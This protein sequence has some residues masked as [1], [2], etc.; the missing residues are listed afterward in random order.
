MPLSLKNQRMPCSDSQDEAATSC[1]PP[2]KAHTPDPDEEKRNNPSNSKDSQEHTPSVKPFKLPPVSSFDKEQSEQVSSRKSQQ[3]YKPH[4]WL[5]G[6]RTVDVTSNSMSRGS[7]SE[8]E[9]DHA[10]AE[11][12][13]TAVS[14]TGKETTA[15]SERSRV[16]RRVMDATREETED[17]AAEN[18]NSERYSKRDL[19]SRGS[20]SP[21]PYQSDIYRSH[22]E[23]PSFRE[24]RLRPVDGHPRNKDHPIRSL[25]PPP[26][27]PYRPGRHS[28]PG[29]SDQ[30]V[31][32]DS[33]GDVMQFRSLVPVQPYNSSYDQAV[34]EHQSQALTHQ[35]P[36]RLSE[37]R[38]ADIAPPPGSA[39]AAYSS[40]LTPFIYKLFCLVSD[41]ATN[42]LC[43]WSMNGDSF[44]VPDPTAFAA[45][46]LP[47]YFKHNQFASFVRQLN[48]YRFHKLTPGTCIFGHEKFLKDRPDLLPEIVRQRSPDRPSSLGVQT[49]SPPFASLPYNSSA[50]H[51]SYGAPHPPDFKSTASH[52]QNLSDTWH[53]RQQGHECDSGL[54]VAY[55]HD[56]RHGAASAMQKANVR[57]APSRHHLYSQN[58]SSG[59]N[60]DGY[61]V[62]MYRTGGLYGRRSDF[63]QLEQ[64]AP[65]TRGGDDHADY[66]PI[67]SKRQRLALD[68]EQPEQNRRVFPALAVEERASSDVSRGLY[69][70][71]RRSSGGG[72]R[73]GEHEFYWMD[74]ILRRL[75]ALERGQHDIFGRVS[76]LEDH[77]GRIAAAVESIEKT[78]V[79]DRR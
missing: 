29:L 9:V 8:I 34:N 22:R 18:Q 36:L 72:A 19:S 21:R 66:G 71:Q 3:H 45:R 47:Q 14:L 56:Y 39:I 32:P 68:I 49:S 55:G 79:K 76:S 13:K 63:L 37:K 78:L 27:N 46:V 65:R 15:D 5:N 20:L 2:A 31:Q 58:E 17:D 30:K 75:Q 43:H 77:L 11:V 4:H 25:S 23:Q 62:S 67:A 59:E 6:S 64:A 50:P 7:N 24:S 53:Y 1:L 74:G 10:N 33:Y 70:E 73:A 26:R 42:D 60:F 35:Q 52:G 16:Q 51:S 40:M 69:I 38:K 48:K 61:G 44:V 28:L 41:D 54:E 57:E 12:S